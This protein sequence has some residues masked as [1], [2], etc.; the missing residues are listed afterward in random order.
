MDGV[1][2]DEALINLVR[3]NEQVVFLGYL[4]DGEQFLLRHD[5]PGGVGGIAEENGLGVF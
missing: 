3:D 2:V 1:T 5:G 4:R